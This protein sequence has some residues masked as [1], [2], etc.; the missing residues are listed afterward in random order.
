MILEKKNGKNF[1]VGK[2][3]IFGSK[4][5]LEKSLVC[6]EQGLCVWHVWVAI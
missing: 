3:P 6:D 1:G 2:P 4:M 5:G